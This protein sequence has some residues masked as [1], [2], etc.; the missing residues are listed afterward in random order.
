MA[1]GSNQPLL[2]TSES[3]CENRCSLNAR[4]ECLPRASVDGWLLP[5]WLSEVMGQ[6]ISIQRGCNVGEGVRAREEKVASETRKACL[7]PFT[8]L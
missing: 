1:L 8:S 2:S 5:T 3:K 4:E 7:P 6:P